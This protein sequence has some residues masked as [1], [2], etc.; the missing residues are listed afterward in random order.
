MNESMR[1]LL[2]NSADRLYFGSQPMKVIFVCELASSI[3]AIGFAGV[4]A[5]A[6]LLTRVLHF[7]IRLLLACTC[8]AMVISNI[9]MKYVFTACAVCAFELLLTNCTAAFSDLFHWLFAGC[10]KPGR[11]ADIPVEIKQ[12]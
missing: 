2:R 1:S 10:S 12:F 8:T 5:M 11:A 9:G 3:V 6:I 4:M 7:N